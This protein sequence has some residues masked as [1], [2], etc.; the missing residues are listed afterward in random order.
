MIV[1]AFVLAPQLAGAQTGSGSAAG[2]AAP[3]PSAGQPPPPPPGPSAAELHKRCADALNAADKAGDKV[4]VGD[5]A[6]VANGGVSALALAKIPTGEACLGAL[7]ASPEFQRS[8]ADTAREDAAK[9]FV[10]AS[11]TMQRDA[12]TSIARNEKHVL[13]AYMAMWVIA[14]GFLIFMWRRQQRLQTEIAQLRRD[15]E[16]AA[17]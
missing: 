11:A 1:I 10:A 17:K 6:N 3:E 16:A 7:A 9:Q 15:L 4:F 5:V 13:L 2:S 8:V 14:A 12:A